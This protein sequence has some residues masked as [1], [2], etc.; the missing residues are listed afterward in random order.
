MSTLTHDEEFVFLEKDGLLAIEIESAPLAG[1]WAFETALTGYTGKGYYTWKGPNLFTTPGQGILTYKFY[2]T[3]PGEYKLFIYNRHDHPDRTE[4]NDAWIK[5]NNAKWLKTYSS[6]NC[7]WTWQTKYEFSHG[8]RG[9]AV[10]TLEEGLNVIQISGRSTDFSIARLV[11]CQDADKG[12]D[13]SVEE[14][15][16]V[17]VSDL[18]K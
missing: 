7:E 9:H 17:K 3:N 10:N 12:M 2:V 11:F 14:S 6:E 4:N 13:L 18:K 8:N 5:V 16:R 15:P 1:E